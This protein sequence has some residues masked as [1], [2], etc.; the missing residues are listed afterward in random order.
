MAEDGPARRGMREV[1]RIAGVTTA[2]VGNAL[3]RPHL[4]AP[5]TRERIEAAI[6]EVGLVRSV[7]AR[8]LRGMPS[9]VV[10]LVILDLGNPFYAEL[11]RGAEDRLVEAGCT[12]TICST[13]ARVDGEA[14]A[15]SVLEEQA[16]RGIIV[17]PVSQDAARVLATVRRGMPVV[18]LDHTDD[19]LDLCSASADS[20][21]GSRLSAEHLLGLGHRRL[22]FVRDS[23]AVPSVEKRFAATRE[24]VA[25]AGLDPDRALRD[26]RL[27][28]GQQPAAAA[29][30]I[31]AQLAAQKSAPT[32]LICQND[33]IALGVLRGLARR[34]VSVPDDVSVVGYDDLPYADQLAPALTTVRQPAAELGRAAADLL[35][36]EDS[37]N[38]VHRRIAFAP[39]L[40]VRGSTAAAPSGS[41]RRG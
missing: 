11:G 20:S 24:A 23:G 17:T 21:L 40:I 32:G 22:A 18:L 15:L 6:A 14:R 38:H 35:L 16:V 3:N 4:V 10:G 37:P 28:A 12:L 34:G 41:A 29:E 36:A 31:A 9:P 19:E 33:V 39:Q 7:P 27:P 26:V 13:D 1:A 2:T 8:L 25:A 5:A 30:T